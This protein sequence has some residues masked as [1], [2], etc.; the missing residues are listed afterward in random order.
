MPSTAAHPS[1]THISNDEHL[2]NTSSTYDSGKTLASDRLSACSSC[3]YE[4]P[5]EGYPSRL[6]M[7]HTRTK[8]SMP[9]A[10]CVAQ[11]RKLFGWAHCTPEIQ[12]QHL[13]Q[14]ERTVLSMRRACIRRAS[15]EHASGMR[16]APP[17]QPR[18]RTF[19][20]EIVGPD[21]L[22]DGTEPRGGYKAPKFPFL[23]THILTFLRRSA[24][25]EEHMQG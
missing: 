21:P 16:Q 24:S 8:A 11:S 15:S 4:L 3:G 2:T 7:R 1:H 9:R 10:R 6:V 12:R 23:R 25:I 20:G 13:K 22:R 18:H 19:T 5:H 14:Y 17:I